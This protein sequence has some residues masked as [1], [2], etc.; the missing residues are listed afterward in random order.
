M[1]IDYGMPIITRSANDYELIKKIGNGTYSTVQLAKI[2][3]S[4]EMVAIKIIDMTKTKLSIED[5]RKEIEI[6]RLMM[7]DNIINLISSICYKDTVWIIMP[8]MEHTL[9]SILKKKYPTGIKNETLLATI[10]YEVLKGLEYL[11]KNYIIHRDLK[12]NNILVSNKGEVKL[13]DFGVSGKLIDNGIWTNRHTFI[14][15]LAF[16]APEVMEQIEYDSRADI[17]SFGILALELAY[18]Y[19]P[20]EKYE[21]LKILIKTMAEEPPSCY[22]YSD[23]SYIFHKSFYSLVSKCLKKNPKDRKSITKLLNHKFFKF[24]T[25]ASI[26]IENL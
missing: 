18:G 1:S 9:R 5:L 6:M 17:W 19:A 11:H 14:G 25:N 12:S 8:Y 2:K 24:R 23:T 16:M 7:H 3:D 20:Y 13:C 10:L 22:T 4:D 21:P 26:I 15:T